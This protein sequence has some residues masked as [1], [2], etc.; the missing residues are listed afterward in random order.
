MAWIE[1][2]FGEMYRVSAIS[3]YRLAWDQPTRDRGFIICNLGIIA[4]THPR[5]VIA[6]VFK[7]LSASMAD[8][9]PGVVFDV[10]AEIDSTQEAI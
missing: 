2:E 5:A 6:P 1:T 8:E 9:A 3:S 7:A 10:A 4:T